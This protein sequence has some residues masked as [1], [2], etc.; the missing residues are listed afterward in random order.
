MFTDARS[1][2]MVILFKILG[3]E[4]AWT[5]L[6]QTI[7]KPRQ[8]FVT[9]SRFLAEKVKESFERYYASFVTDVT[10]DQRS[11]QVSGLDGL[12]RRAMINMEEEAQWEN[13]LPERLGELEDRHFPLFITFDQ[14]CSN[15]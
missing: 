3:I 14:V 8:M 4:R 7:P 12:S 15:P 5:S 13:N 1:K 10:F 2:T 9:K 11:R 6:K